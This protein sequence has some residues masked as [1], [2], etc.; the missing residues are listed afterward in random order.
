MAGTM[1]ADTLNAAAVLPP[2]WPE[3][4]APPLAE[5]PPLGP[6]RRLL[7]LEWAAGRDGYRAELG[8][9]QLGAGHAFDGVAITWGWSVWVEGHPFFAGGEGFADA[10]AAQLAAEAALMARLEVYRPMLEVNDGR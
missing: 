8:D 5:K 10:G 2:L 3:P 4:G 1:T 9:Y 6:V 7:R